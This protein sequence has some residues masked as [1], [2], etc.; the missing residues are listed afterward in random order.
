MTT[1]IVLGTATPGG[2]FPLYGGAFAE[3]INETDP[4]LHV[5][6]RN[7]KG[8]TDSAVSVSLMASAKAPP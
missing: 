8:S 6:P 2:G 1:N 3:T 4:S 5:E 7:T